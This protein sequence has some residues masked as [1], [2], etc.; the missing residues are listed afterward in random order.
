[1]LHLQTRFWT[2]EVHQDQKCI[3]K[4]QQWQ[5]TQKAVNMDPEMST[6]ILENQSRMTNKYTSSCIV[7]IYNKW[8]HK[9][10][11]PERSNSVLQCSLMRAGSYTWY[12]FVIGLGSNIFQSPEVTITTHPK[13]LWRYSKIY[14]SRTAFNLFCHYS[15]N[16]ERQC[17]VP[18]GPWLYIMP[19]LLNYHAERLLHW[20]Y[21][22]DTQLICQ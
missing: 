6:L 22:K 20:T 17:S 1:M 4:G 10:R 13:C 9:N 2:H 11:S 8:C 18:A 21:M 3:V 19:I 5:T 15:C 14:I 16:R 12:F 7:H